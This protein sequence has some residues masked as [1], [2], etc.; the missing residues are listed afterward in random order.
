MKLK[1][2]TVRALAGMILSV[3]AFVPNNLV[4]LTPVALA[5]ER[6]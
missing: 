6:L 5:Q 1:R 3:L 2:L 4:H